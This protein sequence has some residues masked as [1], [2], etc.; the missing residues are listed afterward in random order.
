MTQELT[1][2]ERLEKFNRK[3]RFF[4]LGWSL[5]NPRFRASRTFLESISSLIGTEI[6][7]SAFVAMDYHLTWLYPSPSPFVRL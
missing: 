6:P 5:G 4:L 3:E 1:F 7:A 2:I